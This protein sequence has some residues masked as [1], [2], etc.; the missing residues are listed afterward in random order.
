[1]RTGILTALCL[2]LCLASL[3]FGQDVNLANRSPAAVGI[4][5]QFT[6]PLISRLPAF[7]RFVWV[8]C[9]LTALLGSLRIYYRAQTGT[10]DSSTE[11]WRLGSAVVAVAMVATFLQ[12]WTEQNLPKATAARFGTEKLIYN[13]TEDTSELTET[14]AAP[15]PTP[16][17]PGRD[18]GVDSVRNYYRP[19]ADSLRTANGTP[20]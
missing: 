3:A 14:D 5:S 7:L 1:M 4:D 20:P 6:N 8:V 11:I 17:Q 19:L 18:P 15:T 16:Y 12:A 13:G 10:G 9:G 2:V